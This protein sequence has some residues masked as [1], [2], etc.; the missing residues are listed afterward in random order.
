MRDTATGCS[1]KTWLWLATFAGLWLSLMVPQQ[2]AAVPAY[3]RQVK[4]ECAACHFQHYPKLNAFGRAFKSNGYSQTSQELIEGDRLSI[5]PVLNASVYFK[6]HVT[7]TN[8]VGVSSDAT[9]AFPDEA[10]LLIGGRLGDGIGGFIEMSE[11][12]L[13]YKVSM[14]RQLHDSLAAGVTVFATD[15]IG[16]P[17]G[18]ELMN[19]GAVANVRPFER[20][21][22]PSLGNFGLNLSGAATGVS[23]HVADADW[24][25]SVSGF[26]PDSAAA[27]LTDM[28]AGGH[29]AG[30]F[31]AA[32]MPTFNG[33]DT[34][35]GVGVF[36]GDTDAT[37][38]AGPSDCP[39]VGARTEFA[40]SAWFIDAQ[41]QG[42]V[43]GK[44][45]GLYFMYVHGDDEV[46]SGNRVNLFNGGFTDAPAGWGLDV[47]YSMTRAVH[48]L[49]SIGWHDNGDPVNDSVT[50]YG[51]GAYWA[52]LQ[53]VTLQGMLE[54][55]DGNNTDSQSTRESRWTAQLETAF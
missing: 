28:D 9:Y 49:G 19:T 52:I 4:M 40:T 24:F 7:E 22:Q 23:V 16:A 14:T 8:D 48:L 33:L 13:S 17:F 26:I 54:S 18:F 30:Y 37:C 50:G 44:D 15:G 55:F 2:A 34:G 51:V 38:A 5:P 3:A 32:W 53:N 1:G 47:E 35:I 31:R 29:L 36:S 11:G 10:A 6:T 42:A 12:I 25:A 27:G 45:L 20:A 41:L 21:A 43:A 46:S 39:V